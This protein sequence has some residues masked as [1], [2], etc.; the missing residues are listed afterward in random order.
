MMIIV[1][2]EPFCVSRIS[3][4]G[5]TEMGE[6]PRKYYARSI[7][8]SN[9]VEPISYRRTLARTEQRRQANRMEP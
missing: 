1:A 8:T 6:S 3:R 7:L 9:L 5:P 2:I 4:R